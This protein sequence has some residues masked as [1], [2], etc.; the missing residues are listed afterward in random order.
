MAHWLCNSRLQSLLLL[1]LLLRVG[2]LQART[3]VLD[4]DD[5]DAAQLETK[6]Y[7]SHYTAIQPRA[8]DNSVGNYRLPNNTVPVAYDVEL[9]TEVDQRV[10][11]F[12]GRV[13]INITAVE[14]SS[15]IT[16]HFR[17]TAN[18]SASI[19]NTDVVT[20]TESL[21]TVTTEDTREFLTLTSTSSLTAGSNYTL[22]INYTGLLRTDQCGFYYS[23]YTDD[24][25]TVQ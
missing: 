16:L 18:F 19:I 21:L 14:A 23:S 9:W 5:I 3:K 13:K 6:G 7:Q 11:N 12:T 24:D 22:T 25:G 4:I 17:Q 15:T 8:D 10:L 2:S 1:L 20:S